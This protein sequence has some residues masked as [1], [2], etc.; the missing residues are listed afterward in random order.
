VDHRGDDCTA[1]IDRERHDATLLDAPTISSDGLLMST[2]LGGKLC[3]VVNPLKGLR[4][5]LKGGKGGWF[6]EDE[7]GRRGKAAPPTE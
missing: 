6:R 2:T 3:Q 5:Q 1:P 4:R 7:L